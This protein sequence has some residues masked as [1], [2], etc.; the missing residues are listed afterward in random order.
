MEFT[1][2]LFN[3]AVSTAE[4]HGTDSDDRMITNLFLQ[5]IR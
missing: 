2:G 1:S 3:G 5:D 4:L